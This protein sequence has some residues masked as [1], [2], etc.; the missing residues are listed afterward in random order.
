[1]KLLSNSVIRDHYDVVVVGSGIGGLTAASLLAKQ[2]IGV[3]VIEHHYIPG[4]SCTI[5]RRQGI[6]FD[7]AVGMMFGFGDGSFGPHRYVMNTLEEELEVI[8][9]DTLYRMNIM[10]RELTFW[11]D[12]DRFFEEL[13]AFFPQQRDELRALYDYLYDLHDNVLPQDGML[14]PPT[15]APLPGPDDPEPAKPVDVE[16]LLPLL[17]GN[18][19]QILK[20]FITD[21]EVMAFFNMLTCTY[22]YTTAAETPALLSAAM[23]VDNHEEGVYYPSGSP[24]MLSNKLEKT[25]E[26]DGGQVVCRHRVEEILIRD[27]KAYGVRLSDGTEIGAD[28]VVANATVWNLYGGLI[29]PEHFDPERKKWADSLVPTFGSVCLYI[30]VDHEAIPEGTPP[31]LFLIEDMYSITGSDITIFL[32][33]IDDPSLCPPELHVMTVV[34]PSQLEWPRPSDPAY[35]SEAYLRQKDEEANKLLDQV[36]KQFPGLRKHIRVMDVGTPS[37]IERFTLKNWGAVGGPKQ[38]MGQELMKRLHARSEWENLYQCGDST[39]M[40]VGIV[41]TTVSGIGAANMVL[42]DLGMQEYRSKEFSRE[43]IRLIEGKPWTPLPDPAQPIVPE[44]AARLAT[45]CQLCDDAPCTEVCPSSIDVL[46]FTRRMEA[47]NFAGAARSLRETNPLSEICGLICP[48]ER[49][50][51]KV[52]RRLESAEAPVRIAD[53]HA[54]VCGQVSPAEGFERRTAAP[55]GR[56]VAVVGAGPAGLTC[57]HFLARLGHRVDIIDKASRPGGILSH[58]IPEFRLPRQVLEREIEAMWLP[59]M[60]LRSGEVLGRDIGISDLERDYDAV[61]LALGLGAGRKLELPGIENA[62]ATDALH[63]LAEHRERGRLD[64]SGRVLVIG[65]GS[66]ASDAA[67]TALDSGAGGVTIACLEG[68]DEMP[69]LASEV[70][71]MKRRGV[72]IENGWGPRELVSESRLSFARC[73]SVFDE[74]GSFHPTFDDTNRMELDFDRLVVAVGQCVDS[75]L[76]RHLEQ[77]LGARDI[78]QVDETLQL[79]GRPKLFAVGDIIRGAGNAVEAVA[80]GRRAAA[81]IDQRLRE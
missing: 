12:F 47:Q 35:R 36:E 64:L 76:A 28:R 16:R 61:F 22:C 53:L 27:G 17:S 6:T 32:S 3:L 33:S 5:L 40:G 72:T 13:V 50:C 60:E 29:K 34:Q 37:T 73:T 20:Q 39:V 77:E 25:I 81:A 75:E 4:G 68:P 38:M 19:E 55:S 46:A 10:G 24:Q 21:P 74:D 58:A 70:D 44:V 7:A 65:G 78:L 1:M 11:R 42:R 71:E 30:A 59:G 57:A 52:C 43:Y 9:H 56:R 8:P 79:P 26:R 15:E 80:D 69:A 18:T 14:V 2:G 67:L 31:I 63:L 51:Q 62:N 41:A 49:L 48:A 66:V 45:E 23:F 54:W